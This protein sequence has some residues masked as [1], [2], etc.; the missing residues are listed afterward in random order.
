MS[1]QPVSQSGGVPATFTYDGNLRRVKQVMDGE[2]VYS[3]YDASGTLVYQDNVT[4]G[5]ATD[6]VASTELYFYFANGTFKAV[7]NLSKIKST[8]SL[9][10]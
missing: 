5:K 8:C 3:V 9:F 7:E 10:V 2:T 4:S 1:D 6:C